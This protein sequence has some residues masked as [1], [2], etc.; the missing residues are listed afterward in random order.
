M[1]QTRK[2]F[3]SMQKIKQTFSF[4][5][6]QALVEWTD[7]LL[8][9][10]AAAFRDKYS[11]EVSGAITAEIISFKSL[12]IDEIKKRKMKSPRELA[13]FLLIE[14]KIL[15]SS[16]TNLCTAYTLLLTL[17]VT[18]SAA[19]RSFSKLKLIQ[20]YLRSTMSQARLSGLSILSI[21]SDRTNNLYSELDDIITIFL[22]SKKRR[23]L[24]NL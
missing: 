2:R 4:L 5:N 10:S 7:D 8:I 16:F 20:N 14:N 18:S 22:N 21:E 13:E 6:P 11:T 9:E 24:L 1:G 15:A 23:G 3:L 17:P 19:E 12:V